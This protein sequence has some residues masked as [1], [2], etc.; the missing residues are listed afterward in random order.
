MYHGYNR[1][2]LLNAFALLSP[3][4]PVALAERGLMVTATLFMLIVIVPVL[5]LLFF[6]AWRYKARRTTPATYQPNWHYGRMEELVWWAIP[7]EIILILGALTWTSTHE[8]DPRRPLDGGAPLIVQVVALD[9]K[10]LFIYPDEGVASVNYAAIPVDR[11]VRFEVTADAPMNSFWIPRL[12]GQI[13]AMTGMVNTLNL[14]AT[15]EGRFEGLSANY[16]GE[17]FAHMRF[18]AEAVPAERF[19][20]WVSSLRDHP[21]L[22]SEAYRKLAAPSVEEP[23]YY[24]EV[25]ENLY[26]TIVTQFGR[27]AAPAHAT[28]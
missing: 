10:W 2:D 19:E 14:K 8:L 23:S 1:M 6:F 18:I 20:E 25:E 5:G 28:H 24:G 13:Y 15:K 21:P 9:W 16:S 26:T 11:P 12:G 22:D 27:A 4:G 3:H 17:G 7:L